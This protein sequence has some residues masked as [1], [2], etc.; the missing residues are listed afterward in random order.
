MPRPHKRRLDTR[1]HV[2]PNLPVPPGRV[3]DAVM[4]HVS[5][6]PVAL[7]DAWA[8]H[9]RG[10]MVVDASVVS[11]YVAE[12]TYWRHLHMAGMLLWHVDD[13]MQRREAFWQV[14]AA[15][16][17]HWLGSDATGGVLSEGAMAPFVP[18]DVVARWREVVALGYA[19]DL[20][21][22]NV[23]RLLFQRGF[24]RF[25]VSP[26]ELEAADPQMARW[27]RSVLLDEAFWRTLRRRGG[28]AQL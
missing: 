21:E 4:R 6:L 23:P 10:E 19:E 20:L 8:A 25:M 9:P 3:R 1:I 12:P 2:A 7:R 5:R 13:V 15:W 14:V 18:P 26:R 17:D 22:T 16:L 27:F 28:G 24:A 11:T